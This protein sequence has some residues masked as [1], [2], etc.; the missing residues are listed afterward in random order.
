MPGP[1][2][3]AFRS[4]RYR[5]YRLF[6]AGQLVSLVGAWMQNVA[7]AWLVYRLTG[8]AA[9]LGAIGFA[10]QIP[11]FLLGP[12]GGIAADRYSRHRIVIATQ[13]ASMALALALATLTFTGWIGI[14]SL[15][16]LAA[17]LG[18]VNAIDIPARQAFVMDMVGR[19]DLVN[20]IA[21]N[22]TMFNG[23]RVVGPAVAGLL[24]AWA[25][26]AWCFLLNGLSY[27][28]VIAGLSMMDAIPPPRRPEGRA[29]EHAMEGFRFVARTGPVR[30]LLL[31]LG[32]VSVAGIPYV[33]LMPIFADRVLQAGAT[34]L[35][36]L[37]GAAGVGAL[38]GALLLAARRSLRGLNGMAALSA[39]VFG[40]TLIAFS[41]SR[42]FWVSI[43][44]LAVGGFFL[45][46]QMG[47]SNTLVQSMSPDALRGRVMAAYSMM[48]MGMAPVGS[49]IAGALAERWGAPAT[50]G[51]GG[52]V[53]LAAGG[54]FALR[55]PALRTE[56][57]RLI[58]AQEAPA[59][60]PPQESA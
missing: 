54:L 53:C 1:F 42:S 2:R 22:S 58:V 28:A 45:M 47:A 26:E 50:V 15:F 52:L 40:A 35:G 41:F 43:A 27:V 5:N 55:V 18:A 30:A 44:L 36:M 12:L 24:V 17:A 29:F 49:L 31:L 16:V 8:S 21:L 3:A 60:D 20:A 13:A 56:A 9:M 46:L 34:G 48:F 59:G 4:L 6:A 51:L 10:G 39:A 19:A 25:G 32:V 14:P 11:V 57:R 7:Q 38:G 33:V 37:M 23:A